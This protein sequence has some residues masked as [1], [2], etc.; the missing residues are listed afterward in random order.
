MM[1]QS[2]LKIRR[3]DDDDITKLEPDNETAETALLIRGTMSVVDSY[4]KRCSGSL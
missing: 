4:L 1:R 2:S 3:P